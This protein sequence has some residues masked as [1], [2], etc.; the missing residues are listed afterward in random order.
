MPYSEW[1]TF[2]PILPDEL[3]THNELKERAFVYEALLQGDNL[4]QREIKLLQ[5][6]L[7]VKRRKVLIHLETQFWLKVLIQAHFFFFFFF[8]FIFASPLISLENFD[9]VKGRGL[10]VQH[11]NPWTRSGSLREDV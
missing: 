5:K 4:N 9:A 10:D 6:D 11:Q 2:R 8:F 1:R 3:Q 7:Q